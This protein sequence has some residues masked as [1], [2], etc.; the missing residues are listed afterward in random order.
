MFNW[1]GR[2]RDY[3]E[4]AKEAYN[5]VSPTVETPPATEDGYTIGSSGGNTVI[6]VT[7]NYNT[8]IMTLGPA[9]VHRMIRLLKASM[10]QDSEEPL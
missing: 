7:C 6:K 3:T 9:E 5:P 8:I 10:N 1:F 4:Q 2:A